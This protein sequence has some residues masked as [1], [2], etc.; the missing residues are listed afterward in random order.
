VKSR[1]A[2][3]TVPGLTDKTLSRL[4]LFFGA[5]GRVSP[6][7][8]GRLALTLFLTPP[9]RKL[10]AVDVP[11]LTRARRVRVPIAGSFLQAYEWG[12]P[13]PAV[14]LLHGWGSHAARFGAFVD[15]FLA[16]GFRVIG[17]DAP[18]HGESSGKQS[19]LQQIRAAL[20]QVLGTCGPVRAIV[21]HSL[22]AA[23]TVE[24][25]ADRPFPGVNALVVVG[26]PRDTAYMM[27]SF[28]LVLGLREEV[29]AELR[30][31]FTA[32]F[33]APPESFS[34][35]ARAADIQLPT[36]VVHD[37]DDD[38]APLAHAEA[39]TGALR[40]GTLLVTQGLN[41]SGPLRDQATIGAI[42]AFVR[43]HAVF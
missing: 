19:D 6:R 32:R 4:R 26:M 33:G 3:R 36:M 38:V 21:G 25:F 31:R 20:E 10:D 24:L 22:G 37:R 30:K 40:A 17:F 15:P 9:R 39:F 14:L 23:A 18:A 12:D 1:E 16:A 27:E 41:H 29:R 28:S 5:T 43:A 11:V 34:T 2:P 42:I 8:A 13:G 7:L 35:L